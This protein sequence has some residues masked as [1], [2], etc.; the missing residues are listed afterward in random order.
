IAGLLVAWVGVRSVFIVNVCSYVLSASLVR[1]I[2][3]S[4]V[5]DREDAGEHRGMRAGFVFLAADRV[6][7]AVT[8]SWVVLVLGLGAVLVAEVQLAASFGP[9]ALWYGLIAAGWG[10]GELAGSLSASRLLSART[11]VPWPGG[12]ALAMAAG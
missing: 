11:G 9:G 12:G 4:F 5:G 10:V 7:R 2:R 1:S 3:G 6:L 8:L